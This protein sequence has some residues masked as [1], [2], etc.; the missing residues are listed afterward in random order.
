MEK[1][2]DELGLLKYPYIKK[3]STSVSIA[4]AA[5]VQAQHALH[6]SLPPHLPP[7]AKQ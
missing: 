4:T 6:L 3:E 1:Q 2:F 5:A 7:V